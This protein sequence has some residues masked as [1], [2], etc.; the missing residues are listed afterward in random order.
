MSSRSTPAGAPSG[1]PSGTGITHRERVHVPWYWW[2]LGGLFAFSMFLAVLVYLGPAWAFG[3]AGIIVVLLA[4]WFLQYGG[5]RICVD[6]QGLHA[7]RALLE[8]DWLGEA[9]AHSA[10]ASR[11]RL[12][13]KADVRAFL[14]VRPYLNRVVEVTVEDPADSHPYWLIGSRRP[15]ALAAAIEAT[16]PRVATGVAQEAR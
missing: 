8:W 13:P 5:A 7:G 3:V 11:E 15:E 4:W 14:L 16:R 9:T 12:G 2:L 6:D 1:T 10:E